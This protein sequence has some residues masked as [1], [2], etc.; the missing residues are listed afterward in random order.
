[1]TAWQAVILGV[2]E[3]LTEYLPVSSTGHL[4]LTEHALGLTKDAST[5]AAADSYTI[6]IQLGAIFAVLGV[7]FAYF[8][9]MLK[10]VFG[11][12]SE[13]LKL[14]CNIIISFVPAAI[15]GLLFV[16]AI[17]QHLFGL[18]PTTIAWF[19]GGI[20]LILWGDRSKDGPGGPG[21]EMK[22]LTTKKALIIGLLQTVA[23]W[24]GTSRSLVTILG[25]RLVGLRLRDSVIYSFLLGMLTL[26][27]STFY[28]LLKDGAHMID[29][30]GV[31]NLL[32]GIG[33][34]WLSAWLAVKGMVTYLKKHGLKLFGGYRVA[35]AIVTALLIYTGVLS[36]V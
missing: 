5:K 11:K 12:S 28:D 26:S 19:I 3:G 23:V 24:P 14:L 2:V 8:L 22:D 7:Y 13:G 35:L 36:H 9:L 17:K 15:V 31:Q 29:V 30:F 33:T 21:L 6:V 18:W 4:I 1:M 10:G 20:A 32:I 25:G 27:A 16:G 34:A